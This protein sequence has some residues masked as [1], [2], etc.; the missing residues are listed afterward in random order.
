MAI[1][2]HPLHEERVELEV[3]RTKDFFP[4][5]I[6]QDRVS[7]CRLGCSETHCRPGKALTHRVEFSICGGPLV[8]KV[9]VVGA[10][11]ILGL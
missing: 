2:V 3:M 11:R 6:F 1:H 9:C 5:L 10:L 7:L 8:F 4:F